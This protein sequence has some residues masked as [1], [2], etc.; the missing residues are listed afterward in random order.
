[1]KVTLVNGHD[2]PNFCFS[3]M[4]GDK[5][6]HF[7]QSDWDYASLACTLG[8]SVNDIQLC[9]KCKKELPA[10][11]D[12]DGEVKCEHCRRK[13][14]NVQCE[15]SSDGTVDCKECGV[16][17]SQFLSAAY[18]Y[19]L[20]NDGEEFDIDVEEAF[21]YNESHDSI[22][23]NCGKSCEYD[24]TLCLCEGCIKESKESTDEDCD[25]TKERLSV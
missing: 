7:I 12:F 18:D 1:M 15:H 20:E 23:E 10:F 4:D 6:I 17:T 22:C 19:L 5:C 16:T 14:G 24:S 13:K 9:R 21:G 3:V 8:W 25:R 2:S 11:D